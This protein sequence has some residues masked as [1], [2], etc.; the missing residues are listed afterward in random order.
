[1]VQIRNTETYDPMPGIELGDVGPKF[2]YETKDNGYMIIKNVRIP[3]TDM[4]KRYSEVLK[5]GTFI[6][7]G[8]LKT[9]YSVMLYTRVSIA[10][11]S[12]KALAS[13][14]QIA[15][16]YAA[17]RRQFSTQDGTKIERRLIDYQTHQF[18]I[19]PLVA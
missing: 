14:I 3:R 2:G 12:P 13:S 6:I 11:W 8:D 4:L 19:I 1:M 15:T 9:L 7:K 10:G 17:V 18:K 5:D 16:R